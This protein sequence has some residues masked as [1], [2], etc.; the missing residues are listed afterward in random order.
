VDASD[1]FNPDEVALIAVATNPGLRTARDNRGI[2]HA[3]VIAAGVLPNPSLAFQVYAPIAGHT[4]GNVVGY[5]GQL[6]WSMGQLF[7]RGPQVEA[8]QLAERSIELDVAWSEWQVAMQA[9]LLVFQIVLLKRAVAIH[10]SNVAEISEIVKSVRHAAAK[11]NTTGA[12]LT[13]TEA[14][15]AQARTAK[16]AAERDLAVAVESL[17]GL[18]GGTE[19]VVDHLSEVLP[20][21]PDLQGLSTESLTA[22]LAERRADLRAMHIALE[23]QDAAYEAATRSAFPGI[24]VG[25]QV[26]RDAGDFLA[27]GPT[28]QVNLP[29]FDQGRAGQVAAQAQ[30]TR[31]D[32]LFAERINQARQRIGV[33]LA[34]AGGTT[35]T[36]AILDDAI[37]RQARLVRVYAEARSRDSIDILLFDSARSTLVQLQ[38][39][40]LSEKARFWQ[41]V[42]AIKTESGTFSLNPEEH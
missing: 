27:L 37:E 28:A 14:T 4:S 13:N 35:T 12:Q 26:A 17:K 31:L 6:N 16:A 5:T 1:G 38:L 9:E 40:R 42:V 20:D 10:T 2:A 15:L 22:R 36:L 29:L 8:A 7:T 19:G 18:L 3:Q 24:Q 30:S 41:G 34:D 21:E 32:D 25:F 23:S 11:G 33:S 39:Q